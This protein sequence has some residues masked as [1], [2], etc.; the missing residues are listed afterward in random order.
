MSWEEESSISPS[1]LSSS[2]SRGAAAGLPSAKTGNCIFVVASGE[3][4]S[5]NA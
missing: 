4:L 1:A 3:E 5:V 2:S